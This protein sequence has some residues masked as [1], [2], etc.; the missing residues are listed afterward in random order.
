M[1]VGVGVCDVWSGG[2]GQAWRFVEK[3]WAWEK[4]GRFLIGL[5]MAFFWI[6]CGATGWDEASASSHA[7]FNGMAWRREFDGRRELELIVL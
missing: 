6:T 5:A 4:G 2:E 3:D 1:S 7:V